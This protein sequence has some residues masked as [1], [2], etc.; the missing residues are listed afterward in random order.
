[1]WPLGTMFSM[2]QRTM[3]SSDENSYEKLSKTKIVMKKIK[4]K[5]IMSNSL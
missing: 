4:K 5:V 1:M 3:D 2:E